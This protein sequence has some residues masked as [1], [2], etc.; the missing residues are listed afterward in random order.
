MRTHARL[1]SLLAA[2]ALATTAAATPTVS[3]VRVRAD[4]VAVEV[5]LTGLPPGQRVA[6]YQIFLQFDPATFAFGGG[7]YAPQFGLQIISPITADSG[8]IQLAAGINTFTGQQPITGDAVLATLHFTQLSTPCSPALVIQADAQP[9]TR[10]TDPAGGPI[11]PLQLQSLSRGCAADYNGQ[12]GIELLDIFDFLKDWFARNCYADLNGDG[13]DLLDIF[14]FLHQW[15][16]RC[17]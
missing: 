15:F 12:N 14:D 4:D 16:N 5:R 6:G 3:L 11:S 17:N 1:L 8:H 10:L 13:V 2:A 7:T 9:P